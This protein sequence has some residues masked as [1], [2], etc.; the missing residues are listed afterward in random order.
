MTGTELSS[1]SN[2]GLETG[3]G[4]LNDI[5]AIRVLR[6]GPAHL[7]SKIPHL[8]AKLDER[9]QRE[10]PKV[11]GHVGRFYAEGRKAAEAFGV[12]VPQSTLLRADR[13]IE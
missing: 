7:D 13:V 1:T 12:T 6:Q 5:Q 2:I 4:R 9:L 8:L 11:L 3:D 10:V